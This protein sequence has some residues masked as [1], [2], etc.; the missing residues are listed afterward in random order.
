MATV[1]SLFN[2]KG[3]VSKTTTTFHLGWMLANLGK[4]VLI[5]DADPQC[6]LTGLTLGIDS[7]DDL[8]KFYDSKRNN[9]MY[10]SLAGVFSLGTGTG[11]YKDGVTTT[12]TKNVNLS[13]LAGHIKFSQLDIILA[14]ALTSSGS[15]PMLKPLLSS[16]N[17]LIRNT[18]KRGNFDIV[19]VDMSPS[20]SATNMCIFMASDYFIIP[21]SPDF[22]CY[23]AIDSLSEVLPE[24][25][26]RMKPFKDD[27][28]LPRNN[29]KMLGVIS[30][31][32]QVYGKDDAEGSKMTG[33]FLEWSNKIRDITN[34][35]LAP[36][37]KKI[38]MIVDENLFNK[39]V[40]HDKPYNLAN[41][42][43]FNTLIPTSQKLSK[44]LFELTQEDG[45]WSGG[46]WTR[47]QNNK[48]VGVKHKIEEAQ[49]VYQ[50][51][52]ESVCSLIGLPIEADN[53]F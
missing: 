10:S 18:A 13:I 43:D 6:N 3:G 37:L 15:L 5:V 45:G 32:Y 39:V 29:P 2:H 21:T 19:L 23:Q 47:K 50:K 33:A 52:A 26:T 42:Q 16:I 7:Y 17:T 34:T 35:K 14:T 1:I 36:S 9:D 51:L 30:Q 53:T 8:F 46:P 12:P 49:I 40:E 41:I 27:M 44:P 22:Y 24:W 48:D 11:D 38:D 28:T 4:K 31:N 25:S 20:I